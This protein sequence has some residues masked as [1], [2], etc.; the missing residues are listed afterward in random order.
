MQIGRNEGMQVGEAKGK[1]QAMTLVANN[2][3]A[4]NLLF[5]LLNVKL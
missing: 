4:Q 3:L 5:F 1:Y 2:L